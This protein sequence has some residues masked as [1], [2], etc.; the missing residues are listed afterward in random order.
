MGRPKLLLISLQLQANPITGY[1][2]TPADFLWVEECE[3]WRQTVVSSNPNSAILGTTLD[4]Y[5][6][7]LS[8]NFLIYKMRIKP[9]FTEL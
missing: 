8:L 6:T 4:Y 2:A 7:S 3:L 9:Y 1:S 5:L